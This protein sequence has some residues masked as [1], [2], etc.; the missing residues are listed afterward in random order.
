MSDILCDPH[1]EGEKAEPH[2]CGP[3]TQIDILTN[4]G[5]VETR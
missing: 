5:R 1:Y 3:Y 2:V 4:E